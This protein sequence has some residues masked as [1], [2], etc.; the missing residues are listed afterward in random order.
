[1]SHIW[2]DSF[3]FTNGVVFQNTSAIR[4][5]YEAEA[6]GTTNNNWGG[7][8]GRN[9]AGGTSNG[10][11]PYTNTTY[12]E[13]QFSARTTIFCGIAMKIASNVQET[14]F[15]VKDGATVQCSLRRNADGTLSVVNGSGTVLASTASPFVLPTGIWVY[16]EFKLTPHNTAGVYEVRVNE[17]TWLSG[18]GAN[19]RNSANNQAT[20]V[21]L[22][23]AASLSAYDDFY[24]C[25]DEGSTCNTFYGNYFIEALFPNANGNTNAWAGSDGDS[26]NNYLLVDDTSP[27]DDDTTYVKSPTSGDIDLYGFPDLSAAATAGLIRVAQVSVRARKDDALARQIAVVTRSGGANF[28]GAT[29]TMTTSYVTSY[30]SWE[31]DP[32]TGVAWTGA[33][34]NSAEFGVKM[35]A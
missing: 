9:A 21:R 24:I 19:T 33:N 8:A 30:E 16:I 1:M 35:V 14:I 10:I 27:P 13:K 34:L 23:G 12:L 20:A 3:D 7:A 11:N 31:V 6:D 5:R 18:T 2:H 17:S 26:T 29:K 28:D 32:A 15:Q 25:S 4:A 22:I